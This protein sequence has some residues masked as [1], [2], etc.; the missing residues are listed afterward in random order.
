MALFTG[1]RDVSLMRKINRELMGNIITQQASFYKVDLTQTN[2]NIYGES[3]GNRF[4][5]GPII[6]NC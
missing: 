1:E 2:T 4:Y 6:F 3:N 5:D